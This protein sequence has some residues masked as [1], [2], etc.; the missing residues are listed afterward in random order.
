MV[1]LSG[2]VVVYNKRVDESRSLQSLR[3][4]GF[5]SL[6]VFDNSTEDEVCRYNLQYASATNSFRYICLHQNVGI[7]RAYNMAIEDMGDSDYLAVFDDDTE[8]PNTYHYVM[9]AALERNSFDIAMPIV[10]VGAR[11]VSPCRR[12]RFSFAPVYDL[13]DLGSSFSGINSGLCVNMR[14]AKEHPFNERLFL[15]YVDHDYLDRAS[16]C[17]ASIGFVPEI[18]LEQNLSIYQPQQ[19]NT[20]STIHRTRIF[21]K[22]CLEYYSSNPIRI[23]YALLLIARRKIC[24]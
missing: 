8:V 17:G 24:C 1:K 16:R 4:Q 11:I 14:Y 12:T 2:C 7:S 19:R 6:L 20:E 10:K 5:H 21:E 3:K 15:D 18:T 23:L 9:C 13:E 22:D